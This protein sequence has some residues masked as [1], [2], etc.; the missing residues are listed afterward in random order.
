LPVT[1]D[2]REAEGRLCEAH[3]RLVGRK[4]STARNFAPALAD[5]IINHHEAVAKVTGV[6]I[7]GAGVLRR[8]L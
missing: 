8:C 4:L 2:N 7:A 3:H 5:V 6:T 1:L